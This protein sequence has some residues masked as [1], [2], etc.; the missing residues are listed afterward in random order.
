MKS[1][2][3]LLTPALMLAAALP[4]RADA[5]NLITNG[6]FEQMKDGLPVGWSTPD[7]PG[8]AKAAFPDEPTRGKI[9]QVELLRTGDKGAYFA[10]SAKVKAHTRYRFSLLARMD[11]GKI[12]AAVGGGT[13][14]NKLSMRTLGET[15]TRMPMAPLFWDASWYKNLPFISNQW[16]PVSLEFDS[17]ELTQISVAFGAYFT[18]GNY[19]FDDVSLIEIGPGAA[20]K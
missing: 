13:G 12:T 4:M 15:T 10:Q 11:K 19:S 7:T 14:E 2:P 9:A 1:L 17:G 6:N 18:A 3:L 16:R 5:P 20:Q 8:L